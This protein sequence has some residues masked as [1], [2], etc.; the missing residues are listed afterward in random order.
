MIILGIDPGLVRVGWAV[1]TV[2]S[3]NMRYIASGVIKT[4]ATKP[5]EHRLAMI[6]SKIE[7]VI[8]VHKPIIVGM[9]ETFINANA[10]SS[11]K[12]GYAR[13]AIMALI[14]KCNLKL[15][16]FKPNMIKKTVVGAG[17]AEKQ[18]MVQMIKVLFPHAESV[19]AFDE[20]DALAVAYTCAIFNQSL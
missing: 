14:G 4:T 20:A 15:Q 9:E 19:W 18:Q 7:E 13:G 5:I 16:E 6:V 1:I 2:Q 12:L 10:V 8:F 11:L 3:L 17:H